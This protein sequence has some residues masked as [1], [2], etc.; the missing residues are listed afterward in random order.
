MEGRKAGKGSIHDWVTTRE[1]SVEN[2]ELK[3]SGDPLRDYVEHY[4]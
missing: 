2:L 1:I 3:T 4:V